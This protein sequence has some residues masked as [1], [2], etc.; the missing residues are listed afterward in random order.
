MPI[1]IISPTTISD[2]L[3]WTRWIWIPLLNS[4]VFDTERSISYSVIPEALTP[5]Q[6]FQI[7]SETVNCSLILPWG[8]FKDP[9]SEFLTGGGTSGTLIGALNG[10][11]IVNSSFLEKS[12]ASYGLGQEY[13]GPEFGYC[14]GNLFKEKLYVFATAQN[15]LNFDT[16]STLLQTGETYEDLIW[17]SR[18][19]RFYLHHGK[20]SSFQ[21]ID[22][23]NNI[24][25]IFINTNASTYSVLSIDFDSSEDKI[26]LYNENDNVLN[27]FS[28]QS[29]EGVNGAIEMTIKAQE[30]ELNTTYGSN[31][32]FELS[33]AYIIQDPY[34]LDGLM[35]DIS[36]GTLPTGTESFFR[37]DQNQIFSEQS[38][39]G[40]YIRVKNTWTD[41][42]AD[43]EIQESEI[44]SVVDMPSPNSIMENSESYQW[45]FYP[46][47]SGTIASEIYRDNTRY[48]IQQTTGSDGQL[49][50]EEVVM[51]IATEDLFNE[52]LNTD[53]EFFRIEISSGGRSTRTNFHSPCLQNTYLIQNLSYF[54]VTG[55]LGGNIIDVTRQ[56]VFQNQ[57]LNPRDNADFSVFNQFAWKLN[58]WIMSPSRVHIFQGTIQEISAN[59]IT[60]N[61]SGENTATW[62][63]QSY[64]NNGVRNSISFY[65]RFTEN[66]NHDFNSSPR[67]LYN[68]QTGWYIF[69]EDESTK[70]RVTLI[71]FQ[72]TPQEEGDSYNIVVQVDDT[73]ENFSLGEN[74]HIGFDR[75]PYS[76][77]G[78]FNGS[79]IATAT[80]SRSD[81]S[82]SQNVYLCLD[83]Y[84]ISPRFNG[85]TIPNNTYFGLCG[86]R[87]FGLGV[88]AS[89]NDNAVVFMRTPSG[90]AGLSSEYHTLRQEDLVL[91]Y[92]YNSQHLS[93][94]RGGVHFQEYPQKYEISIGNITRCEPASISNNIIQL[95]QEQE[96]VKKINL[97]VPNSNNAMLFAVGNED[98]Y[99]GTFIASQG[100]LNL[101]GLK[102]SYPNATPDDF[103]Y[104]DQ[105]VSPVYEYM[106]GKK[107]FNTVQ[108][109]NIS[110]ATNEGP[111][112]LK[113]IPSGQQVSSASIEYINN[114]QIIN[115]ATLFDLY[116]C[117]DGEII[118]IMGRS[119]PEFKVDNPN[120]KAIKKSNSTAD[121]TYW[122]NTQYGVMIIGSSDSGFSWGCP[123]KF[124]MSGNNQYG[125]LVLNEVEFVCSIYT[126]TSQEL[127]LFVKAYENSQLYLG[128]YIVPLNS[129]SYKTF[130]CIPSN[131][132]F[133][134][135]WRPPALSEAI[136]T[137]PDTS[138]TDHLVQDGNTIGSNVKV[139][140]VFVRIAAVSES[141]GAQITVD[142]IDDFGIITAYELDFGVYVVFYDSLDGIKML[143]SNN[144]ALSWYASD[145]V[146]ARGAK[147]GIY[148]SGS[149]IYITA[150]GI[151]SKYIGDPFLADAMK[152][153]AGTSSQS[154]EQIQGSFD[155]LSVV[156]LNTGPVPDQRLSVYK[157]D[158]GLFVM[159]YYDEFNKL[160]SFTGT[161][162]EWNFTNNF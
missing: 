90:V 61:V 89:D 149:L 46:I 152:N 34:L 115:D 125:L 87:Y 113:N 82:S 83:G 132:S 75:D 15:E 21:T 141:I 74:I 17:R 60:I 130:K 84:W 96:R 142:N 102:S 118:I 72:S 25:K 145:V 157:A 137:N 35:N 53:T 56:D 71:T 133:P 114:N 86:G 29:V 144:G 37:T 161:N 153:G 106:N 7:A 68:K 100:E 48:I 12:T 77:I 119:F 32:F 134:F 92:D 22:I 50:Y 27:T 143:W 38:I 28:V 158:Y 4:S 116:K 66:Y 105:V 51:E 1:N 5:T 162:L 55:Q 13:L 108:Q 80:E 127:I 59:E 54:K 65:E 8:G 52:L 135:L 147:C 20:I 93:L 104:N 81:T 69:S 6:K 138:F 58:E 85:L 110:L 154:L 95:N 78:T 9:Y 45:Y 155:R 11:D 98:N 10:L 47:T 151:E 121:S 49:S 117:D 73:I 103:K 150:N 44:V 79:Y 111:I 63:Q 88:E 122:S 24:Y 62:A 128:A 2:D 124:D 26:K 120:G 41:A 112:Y 131:D 156:S 70:Y 19:E 140:D 99:Y 139:S 97:V 126:N 33:R 39:T 129:L 101:A 109:L 146:L 36:S 91:F 136:Y 148:C 3:G 94:R 30:N 67:K 23:N 159:F 64:W 18:Y 57:Q 16:T 123:R 42:N 76:K 14:I 40:V 31:I 43:N 107:S 160:A